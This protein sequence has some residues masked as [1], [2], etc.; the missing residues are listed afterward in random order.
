MTVEDT[1]IARHA[2][3]VGNLIDRQWLYRPL[4]EVR[5]GLAQRATRDT[6]SGKPIM[7]ASTDAHAQRRYVDET[8]D[9]EWKMANG[10][11]LWCV[12]RSTGATIHIGG[13]YTWGDCGQVGAAFAALIKW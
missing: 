13:E 12:D 8:W 6:E 10:I 1:T 4:A 7:S 3:M 5:E 11:R 2:V 9:A